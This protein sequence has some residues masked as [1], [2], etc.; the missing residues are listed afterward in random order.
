MST[1]I[2]SQRCFLLNYTSRDHFQD[3]FEI[4]L[5]AVTESGRP[6][7]IE[8][9]NFRPLFFTSRTTPTSF[10]T[11]AVERKSLELKSME[12]TIADCLYFNTLSH[13]QECSARLRAAAF[14]VYESDIHPVERFLMER[15]LWWI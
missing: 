11:L 2:E 15:L 14:P 10:T 4:I 6:V 8:I 1:T 5:H 9:T 7:R 3:R 12:G 13:Y